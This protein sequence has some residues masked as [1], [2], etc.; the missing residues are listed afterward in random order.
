MATISYDSCQREL[1]QRCYFNNLKPKPQSRAIDLWLSTVG[2]MTP[3]RNANM[4]LKLPQ[5]ALIKTLNA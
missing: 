4:S 5:T 1:K 3:L 2:A